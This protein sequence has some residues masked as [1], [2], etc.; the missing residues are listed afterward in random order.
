MYDN[1]G[2]QGGN[3]AVYEWYGAGGILEYSG[4]DVI[5]DQWRT[6]GN[7]LF[8]FTYE[9]TT[10]GICQGYDQ[11]YAVY[12]QIDNDEID[13][14][15]TWAFTMSM[16]YPFDNADAALY[17]TI[18]H[19]MGHA[20]GL[21]D[22]GSGSVMRGYF[23]NGYTVAPDANDISDLDDIYSGVTLGSGTQQP[24]CP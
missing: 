24:F 14:Y 13:S 3:S 12:I 19:E 8:G 21:D 20:L 16:G 4:G 5:I 2:V 6:L 1:L 18:A 15:T 11:A 10:L 17:W 9:P 7:G 23:A 22:N